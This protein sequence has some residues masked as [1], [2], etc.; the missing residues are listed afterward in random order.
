MANMSLNSPLRS[1]PSQYAGSTHSGSTY[2]GSTIS[3]PISR[4]TSNSTDGSG[5]LAVIKQG[6]A[7]GQG[8]P[9]LPQPPGSKKFLILR[10]EALDFHKA[11]GS[12]VAYTILLKDVTNVGRV[13][14]ARHHLRDQAQGRRLVDEPGRRR[15]PHPHPADQGQERRR[16]VR[17]D[18]LHLRPLPRHG[19]A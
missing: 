16:P 12:K 13:E 1:G 2:A 19:R 3:L 18:R 5:G 14:A 8:E 11:E 4:Q 9:Q 7:I 6:W 17:V 10:K 15:R